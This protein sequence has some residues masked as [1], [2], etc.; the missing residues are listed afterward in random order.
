MTGLDKCLKSPKSQANRVAT[1]IGQ[2]LTVQHFGGRPLATAQ[3]RSELRRPVCRALPS[4]SQS[5]RR[6]RHVHPRT[7]DHATDHERRGM[8]TVATESNAQT[9]ITKKIVAGWP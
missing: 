2:G 9:A 3:D 1:T 5:R 6:S 8:T 7:K 4:F